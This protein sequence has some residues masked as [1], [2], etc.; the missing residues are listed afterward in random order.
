[1]AMIGLVAG[2]GDDGEDRPGD[3]SGSASGTEAESGTGANEEGPSEPA[4]AR[5]EADTV[6]AV[7]GLDYEFVLDTETIVGPKVYFVFTNDGEDPHELIVL[8]ADGEELGEVHLQDTG[9]SGDLALE[10]EPGTYTLT[11]LIEKGNET[12]AE[13]GMETTI[14]VE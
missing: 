14:T 10:L 1:M 4:Y 11:C 6:V 2:C 7:Q 5:E 12:H 9:T 3:A 13:L 8:D